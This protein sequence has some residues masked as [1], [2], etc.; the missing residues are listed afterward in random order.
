VIA[1]VVQNPAPFGI[2][3]TVNVACGGASVTCTPSQVSPPNALQ[4]HLFIDGTHL[5]EAGQTIVADYYY[6]LLTAP[7][8]ISFLAENGVKAR[9]NLVSSIQ[10]QIDLS[11]SNRGPRGINAWV[12]G[13]V[14]SISMDNYHGF[15]N[16]PNQAVTIAGGIDYSLARGLIGGIAFS[17]GSL[18]SSLGAFGSF[19]QDE[20]TA[21][22]YA[23]YKAGPI[24][25]NV[26]G[27]YGH[28]DYDV[29]RIVPIGI[30]LQSNTGS[31]SGENWSAAF[32]G[33]Y[34]F[35]NGGL[36]HGPIAGFIYQNVNVGAFTET[37]SFTSL[38]F[39]NQARESSVGQI[40]Y[41]ASYDWSNIQPFAQFTWNHEFADTN[42]NVTGSLTTIAAPSFSLPAVLLGKDWGEVKGGF[43][44]D[45]GRGV[46]FL[47]AGFA[48]FGQNSAAV[49]GGQ[50]GFNVAF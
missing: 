27:T 12:T 2:R 49:Y 41:K 14:S 24:W 42:R 40:G 5:T 16:D 28:L 18:N 48:D 34:K 47:T 38:G 10:T 30:T 19:R 4:T 46:K 20:T 50:I 39:G 22:I 8:E 37:G 26:I 17:T 9:L 33:G 36:T 44:I 1:A 23:A 43:T 25:G 7:S 13:D 32:Q 29:N 6:S 45:V 35:W 11:Q 3:D 15:P 31:T 21:S